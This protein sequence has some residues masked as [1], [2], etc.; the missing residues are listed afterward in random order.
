MTR[1]PY[2][3]HPLFF[4]MQ[5]WQNHLCHIFTPQYL[6]ICDTFEQICANRFFVQCL[7]KH[8]VASQEDKV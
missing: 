5:M 6:H 3:L 2:Y 7:I 8:S 4:G 1:L